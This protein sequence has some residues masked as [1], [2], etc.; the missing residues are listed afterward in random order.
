MKFVLTTKRPARLAGVSALAIAMSLGSGVALAQDEAETTEIADTIRVLGFRQAV[1]DALDTR[2][3][4]NE[5][6]EAIAAEDIGKFPDQNI[7]ESLGRLPGIQID[8]ENGQGTRV[9]I[10]GL[11]QNETVLNGD[12]FL[13]GMEL[14]TIGEGRDR[15]IN[16]LEGI[17][18]ELLA[19][20]NVYKS[21]NAS[22]VE[23]GVGGLIDLQ[24][25]NPLDLNPDELLAAGNARFSFSSEVDDLRPTGAAALGY[26]FDDRF[27]VIGTLSYDRQD[28]QTDYLGGQNRGNWAFSDRGDAASVPTD[29]FAPEY[30]YATDRF[31]ER[32]RLGASLSLAWQATDRLE[33]TA[34]W[35]H[36]DLEILTE[37]ASLKFPFT[38]ESPGLDTSRPYEIDSN[39]VLQSGTFIANSAEA[40]SFVKNFEAQTDNFR[41]AFDYDASDQLRVSGSIAHA[42]ADQ[43]SNS[44]NSDVRYTRY[45]VPT[46]DP[47]SPTGYSHQPA[48]PNAPANF[49]FTYDN[50]GGT[51]PSFSLVDVQDLFS[52]PDYGYFK[53]HWAFG[54]RAEMENTS[55]RL[56]FE[57]TP[58]FIT[59]T[60]V[61]FSF[62][63]RYSDREIDYTAGR[64][65]ADYSGLGELSGLD[66]GENWTPYGYFQDGAIGFRS[67]QLPAATPGRG[68]GTAPNGCTNRFGDSPPLIT[69]FETFVSNPGR[70]ETISGF[71]D[72][73]TAGN[74]T[75]LVQ[76]RSQMSDALGWIQALYP[77]TPFSFFEEPLESFVIGE[78]TTSAYLMMD[79][80]GVDDRFHLNAGAR[81]VNTELT[82]NQGQAPFSPTYFGTDSWN[83]VTANAERTITSRDYTD[84]L[85]SVNAVL[86]VT[87]SIKVR[88]AGARVVARQNLFELGRGSAFEF[89]RDPVSDLFTFT[90]GSS[91]NPTLDPYR[92]NQFD[93]AVEYY[94]AESGLA[95]VTFFRKDVDSF[96]LNETR[97]EFVNDQA[98]GREG[99]VTRPVN[100]EG[101]EIMGLELGIQN[102]Y[103]NGF[104][105][106]VNYTYSDSESPFFNDVDDNLPIPGVAEHAFNAQVYYER[107]R[108]QA[109]AAYSWRDE[110]FDSNFGFNDGSAGTRTFGIWNRAYGQLDAQVAFEVMPGLLLTAEGVN[111]TEE[112]QSQ[113]LQYDNLPFT[114]SSGSARYMFGARYT[115][116]G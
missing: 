67:C 113:Y 102:S 95:F 68:A 57:Y 52:N 19:G 86:D 88:A 27:A 9:R 32:E 70:V 83:G 62:G 65:L 13:T 17:P 33:I 22:L 85:P 50:N 72:S 59:N 40:I 56:D 63:A 55:A 77:N 29:Y 35:F 53:S 111:L 110:S 46:A 92:A 47:S 6:V 105:F 74:G 21:P 114:Y 73:G 84:I 99:P 100:G 87:D 31:Q 48:N 94:F 34:D 26:N 45:N 43:E 39:G 28:I 36:S 14:F 41:L 30:R 78:E 16:S 38:V 18:S 23:G 76:D 20:V 58:D 61:M 107:D 109:R 69:P 89:T 1:Q 112:E 81:I 91:G 64:Y 2:R 12:T 116:G 4:S 93:L 51:L 49:L 5:L 108:L 103:D 11:E 15:E 98:G 25:R 7:A 8:R 60:D 42:M 96:I 24:T 3:N 44:A 104:G 101:G 75:V 97:P 71:W 90:N 106:I 79:V 115:F 37:E 10:R 66:F 54:D 82:V 80:G